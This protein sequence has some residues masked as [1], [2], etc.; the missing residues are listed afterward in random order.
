MGEWGSGG[1]GEWESR[2]GRS[3]S[4]PFPHSPILP[5]SHS[6]TLPL[7]FLYNALVLNSEIIVVGNEVLLGLVQDTNSNYLC[8]VIRGSGGCVRH[9]A[10]VGDDAGVIATELNLSLDRQADLIVTCGGL[11]PT[12]DDL[13]L[14]AIAKA[15]DLPLSS[16]PHAANFVRRRYGELAAQG[17][18]GS[19]EMTEARSK[20]ALFPEG[21]RMIEN[22]VGTAPAM[23]LTVRDSQILSLPGVPAEMKGIVEGPLLGFFA[24]LFGGGAYFER[25]L[26]AV[27]GDESALASVLHTVAGAHPGVYVKSH[28]GRFGADL[29]FRVTLSASAPNAREA[30][31]SIESARADLIRQLAAKGIDSA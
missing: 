15:C 24:G 6:P 25:E 5:L 23:L 14:A 13:T 3:P 30:E 16:D 17:Y 9:I 20:M 26:L 1:V 7:P 27:C 28:A 29:K 31:D 4:L 12:D 21:A 8:R 18:V 19:A 22:P 10:V 11:G 2:P